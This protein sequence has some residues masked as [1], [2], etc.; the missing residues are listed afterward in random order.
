MEIARS[1][2]HMGVCG[3]G[4]R[5]N[6][7]NWW[8]Q[9]KLRCSSDIS[10]NLASWSRAK[11]RRAQFFVG[12]SPGWENVYIDYAVRD[13]KEHRERVDIWE[14]LSVY[15]TWKYLYLILFL[16][17]RGHSRNSS[18]RD[19]LLP[20][21]NFNVK[22]YHTTNLVKKTIKIDT[23]FVS[24]PSYFPV[25]PHLHTISITTYLLISNSVSSSKRL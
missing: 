23:V 25:F 22:L 11:F 4:G 18:S 5:G 7:C 15:L 24:P 3:R 17:T 1:W 2:C 20:F 16:K 19:A 21:Q 10:H 12:Q 13:I 8:S 14:I 6:V 9:A